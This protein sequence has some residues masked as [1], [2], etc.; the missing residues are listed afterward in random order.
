MDSRKLIAGILLASG[1]LL[2]QGSSGSPLPISATVVG[3]NASRRGLAAATTGTGATVVLSTGPTLIAPAL[4]TPASVNL[5]NATGLPAGALPANIRTRAI[6]Y[7]FDG[8]GSALTSGVTKYLTVPFACTIA[9]WNIAVDTG[10][11]TIKTWKIVT[12]TAIP[13]VANTLSTAGVAISSG[14]AVHSTTLSDFS[15]TTVTANDIFGFNLFAVSG[16][17]QV[18]FI[19]ECGQ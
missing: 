2:A 8:G 12:G 14:T 1:V 17:T 16:A 11:A 3:S 19:L 4:G 15:S 6:G 9:A 5:A 18:N 13:T 10:T 7:T